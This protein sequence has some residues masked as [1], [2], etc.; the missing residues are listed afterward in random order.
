M[1][2]LGQPSSVVHMVS[3]TA[4]AD[5]CP[6]ATCPPVGPLPP[7]ALVPALLALSGVLWFWTQSQAEVVSVCRYLQH[8]YSAIV[9]CLQTSSYIVK[10]ETLIYLAHC[11]ELQ[12]RAVTVVF[13]LISRKIG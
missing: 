5:L 12:L 7:I 2:Q 13:L 3:T 6:A 9:D 1:G 4:E 10:N 8:F 11:F